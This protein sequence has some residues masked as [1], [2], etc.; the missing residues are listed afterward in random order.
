MGEDSFI[1]WA[2]CLNGNK[3]FMSPNYESINLINNINKRVMRHIHYVL[4]DLYK[5]N[6]IDIKG[7]ISK[8]H[9]RQ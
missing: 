7:E 2:L 8:D 9:G 1:S 6:T 5:K 4:G 3:S